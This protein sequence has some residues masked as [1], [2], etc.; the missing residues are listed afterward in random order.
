MHY[1]LIDYENVKTS[2]LDGITKLTEEDVVVIFYTDNANTLTFGL[3]RRLNE[4]KAQI[5]FQ[6]VAAGTKNALDF[7]MA[8]YLG[9]AVHENLGKEVTYYLV[10]ND[11]GFSV[12]QLYWNRQKIDVRMAANLGRQQL[13]EMPEKHSHED[14][15]EKKLAVLLPDKS[16]VPVV[17]KIIRDCETR[18]EINGE[19]NRI[20]RP[21]PNDKTVSEI[22][23]AIKSLIAGKP[24][25][26]VKKDEL[27]KQLEA[28]LPDEAL[29]APIAEI[30]RQYDTR[31]EIHIA[32]T[33][34]L[35]T[36]TGRL[37][38]DKAYQAIMPLLSDKL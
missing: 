3:H 22:N 17:A 6:K 23:K 2:G 20:Y 27:E 35:Q 24:G 37:S 8:S 14:E 15:L 25:S 31:A 16:Q 18:Q 13:E 32:L 36:E 5:R 11:Q 33:K 9:Y 10:S 21:G 28:L 19:L 26:P 4:S 7:Q 34:V 1:Y 38:V 29:L 30:I 12:L